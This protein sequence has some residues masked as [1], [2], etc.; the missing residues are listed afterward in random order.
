M[1][2]PG[3]WDRAGR[4]RLRGSLYRDWELRPRPDKDQVGMQMASC[5][6]APHSARN[7]SPLVWM[8]DLLSLAP[9]P[10][11]GLRG[12]P[13]QPSLPQPRPR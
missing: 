12:S 1:L 3:S 8:K 2:E 13:P 11:L 7:P 6:T 5:S 10:S 4:P 9:L